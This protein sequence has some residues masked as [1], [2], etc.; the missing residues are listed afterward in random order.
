MKALAASASLSL[1]N[2]RWPLSF[3]SPI[4]PRQPLI[5]ASLPFS[6]ICFQSSSSK[7]LL[8]LTTKKESSWSA[9]RSSTTESPLSD[10]SERWLLEPIGPSLTV[11]TSSELHFC[12]ISLLVNGMFYL[13]I[14]LKM[15]ILGVVFGNL[16]L[17]FA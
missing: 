16:S 11:F 10:S 3:P 15:M 5:S 7:Q 13:Q 12:Q 6:S 14:S 8:H 9:L 17:Q 2:P 4:F 1:S